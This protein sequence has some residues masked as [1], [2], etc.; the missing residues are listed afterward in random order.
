MLEKRL[1]SWPKEKMPDIEKGHS[2]HILPEL[3]ITIHEVMEQL[4]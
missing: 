2:G 4:T 1:L 3:E